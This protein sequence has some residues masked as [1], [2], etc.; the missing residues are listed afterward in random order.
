M[1]MCK[2]YNV[3]DH[4]E[5]ENTEVRIIQKWKKKEETLTEKLKRSPDEMHINKWKL[6]WYVSTITDVRII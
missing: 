4:V 1:C 3:L 6:C 2:R 5:K